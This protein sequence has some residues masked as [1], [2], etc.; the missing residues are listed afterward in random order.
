[1][2]MHVCPIGHGA[3]I[4]KHSLISTGGKIEM[5]GLILEGFPKPSTQIS[6][7]VP[8]PSSL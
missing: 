1:M 2:L 3:L 7:K 6:K 4:L 5:A 8:S